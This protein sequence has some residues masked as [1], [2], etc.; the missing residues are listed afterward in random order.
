MRIGQ[1]S[2]LN[3]RYFLDGRDANSYASIAWLFGMHDRAH[4]ERDVFGK[5]RY[6]SSAGLERKIDVQQYVDHVRG[7][8]GDD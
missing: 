2:R 7:L 8:N 4:Q 6:M 3:N 5:V 1:R